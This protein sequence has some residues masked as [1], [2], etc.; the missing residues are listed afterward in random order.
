MAQHHHLDLAMLQVER[1]HYAGLP[2]HCCYKR[3]QK[4]L[5]GKAGGVFAFDLHGGDAAAKKLIKVQWFT[6]I[7]VSVRLVMSTS[8]LVL[9]G[10]CRCLV[11]CLCSAWS[12]LTGP[13]KYLVKL[14]SRV[15]LCMDSQQCC[16][17][18]NCTRVI[19][20]HTRWPGSC[21]CSSATVLPGG[22]PYTS[23]R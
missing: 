21:C 9:R 22:L 20:M 5:G 13:F 16:T 7:D 14:L 2:H 6:V 11:W 15:G 8:T 10:G 12:N 4:Y 18:A 3:C 1:V 17:V 19:G 23:L